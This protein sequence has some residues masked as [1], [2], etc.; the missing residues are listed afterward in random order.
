MLLKS[1]K[2]SVLIITWLLQLRLFCTA[3]LFS[4]EHLTFLAPGLV[5][6]L[7]NP[8]YIFVCACGQND[9]LASGSHHA[10]KP[11]RGSSCQSLA[12]L[13]VSPQVQAWAT[14]RCPSCRAKREKYVCRPWKGEHMGSCCSPLFLF[15]TVAKLACWFLQVPYIQKWL[16]PEQLEFVRE[17]L[18][19]EKQ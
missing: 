13:C 12:S 18:E 19:W 16:P 2:Y 8:N 4:P 14:H 9:S 15:R 3:L 17:Q 11:Q 10:W 7:C 6:I 1:N 5:L